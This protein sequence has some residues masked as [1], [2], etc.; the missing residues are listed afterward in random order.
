MLTIILE[1]RLERR[2][3]PEVDCREPVDNGDPS[4]NRDQYVSEFEIQ[5]VRD[6]TGLW[7][8][9]A[10]DTTQTLVS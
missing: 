4:R 6:Y 7:Q 8:L 10:D 3:Q 1:R 5:T 2:P 9:L